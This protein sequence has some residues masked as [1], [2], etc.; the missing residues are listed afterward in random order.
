MR[1]GIREAGGNE[2]SGLQRRN[3]AARAASWRKW[4]GKWA[5]QS[6]AV[7]D[8]II[9][10]AGIVPGMSVLDLACGSGEP[11]LKI[12]TAVGPKG[13]VVAVDIATE[14][15][16]VAEENSVAAGLTN[17]SFRSGDAGELS[18]PDQS[19]DAVTCRFGIMFFTDPGAVMKG[20]RRFLKKG[21]RA[22]FVA[23]GPIEGNPRFATTFGVVLKSLGKTIGSYRPEVF[24]FDR[25]RLLAALMA[26]AGFR[27][28]S[29]TYRTVPYSWDGPPH[30]AWQSFFELSAPFRTLFE[31][32]PTSE[33]ESVR[34]KV[35]ASMAKYYDG[36]KV[37]LTA[38]VVLATCRR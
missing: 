27:K 23:W 26:D 17:I 37:N 24:R 11:A 31:R 21:G 25:P 9:R 16:H 22:C 5:Q 36:E 19:F 15:L 20:V 33:R 3:W 32:V 10:G 4:H 12:A 34:D 1:D 28:I 7:T 13:K 18:F 29:A 8:L 38:K 14:M 2:T 30:E 35:L 6:L